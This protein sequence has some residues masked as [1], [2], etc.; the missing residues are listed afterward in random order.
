MQAAVWRKRA[1]AT[2]VSHQVGGM[3]HVFYGAKRV[4]IHLSEPGVM[5]AG[6]R[7]PRPFYGLFLSRGA[8]V[9]Q[10]CILS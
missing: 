9:I 3:E 8:M 4:C 2:H 1:I 10:I 7:V 6:D 5:I